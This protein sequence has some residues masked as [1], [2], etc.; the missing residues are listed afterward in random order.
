MCVT[1]INTIHYNVCW[2]GVKIKPKSY[3]PVRKRGGGCQ[4]QSTTKLVFPFVEKREKDAEYSETEK[5]LFD[6]KICFVF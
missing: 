4:P 1:I 5:Y 3:G 6:Q 2:E